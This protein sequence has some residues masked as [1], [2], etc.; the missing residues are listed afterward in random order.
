MGMNLMPL[1]TPADASC[2]PVNIIL[3]RD[4]LL[5]GV[6]YGFHQRFRLV[7]IVLGRQSQAHDD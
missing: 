5:R 2:Q 4:P 3:P 7:M 6:Q 1:D